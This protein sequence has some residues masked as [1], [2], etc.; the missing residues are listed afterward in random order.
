[1]FL[2]SSGKRTHDQNEVHGTHARARAHRDSEKSK[3]SLFFCFCFFEKEKQ[4]K[5]REEHYFLFV[6]LMRNHH[7]FSILFHFVLWNCSAKCRKSLCDAVQEKKGEKERRIE[8]KKTPTLCQRFCVVDGGGGVCVRKRGHREREETQTHTH[9]HTSQR[10]REMKNF[11]DTQQ[12]RCFVCNF[13]FSWIH[14]S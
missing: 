11:Y 13:I 6:I 4:R 3:L 1:V 10:E 14:L 8:K 5:D 7:H 9:T 12:L 2:I